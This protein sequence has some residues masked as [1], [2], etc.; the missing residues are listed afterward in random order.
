MLQDLLIGLEIS[1]QMISI[2]GEPQKHLARD[3]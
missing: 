3:G 1:W 2:M